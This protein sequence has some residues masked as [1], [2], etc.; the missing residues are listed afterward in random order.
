M[1]EQ[2]NQAAETGKQ[3]KVTLQKSPIRSRSQAKDTIRSLGLHRI[4]QSHVLPDNPAV[5]GMI[6]SVREWVTVE[7]ID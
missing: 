4:R 7:E 3:L 1:T 6:Q 5:R 2:T